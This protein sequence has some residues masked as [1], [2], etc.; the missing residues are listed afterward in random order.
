MRAPAVEIEIAPPDSA[1]ARWCLDQYYRDL[2]ARLESG[3]D[4][5]RTTHVGEAQIA[6][7]AGIFLIARIDGRAVGCGA[8]RVIDKSVG[9]VKGMWVHADARRRGIAR[10][11]VQKRSVEGGTIN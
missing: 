4:P 7:P 8:L 9:E 11:A 5:E 3:F 6:P 10:Q 1:D 2:A